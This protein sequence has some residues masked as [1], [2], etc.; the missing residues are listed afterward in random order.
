[1]NSIKKIMIGISNGLAWTAYGGEMIKI[2]AVL[3]PGKVNLCLPGNSV[4]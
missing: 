4:M 3:M 2:E 1:M